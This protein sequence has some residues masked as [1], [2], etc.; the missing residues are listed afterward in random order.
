MEKIHRSSNLCT[1][2]VDKK[3][4]VLTTPLIFIF[5][6]NSKFKKVITVPMN[7]V[8][9]G[10]SC[11]K[12]LWSLCAPM[13]GGQAEAAVLHDYLY[14]KD[15]DLPYTRKQ[16]DNLFYDAMVSNGV[17]KARAW[18]IYMGVRAGGHWSFK[19]IHSVE[20]MR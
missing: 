17:S 1:M 19:R 20:K 12:V 13:S 18:L 2:K 3:L 7:F 11:P 9:D 4:W 5:I 16:A 8:T 14:S 15:C 10:A 6:E